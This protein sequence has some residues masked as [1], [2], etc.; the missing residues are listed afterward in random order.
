MSAYLITGPNGS[1]KSTVGRELAHSGFRVFETDI[2]SGISGWFD[3]AT[4]KRVTKL[5]PHPFSQEWLKNHAWL[6]D[7]QRLQEII[8]ENSDKVIFFCGGAY[9]QKDLYNLFKKHFTLFV[10]D[11]VATKRLQSR[12]EGH[13]WK[14]GSAELKKMLDWNKKSKQHAEN[15]GSVLID[16]SRSV[17]TIV[18]EILSHVETDPR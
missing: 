12:G 13:R 6:W 2:E 3:T 11:E 5:P 8:D 10:N 7:Q 9:N 14:D 16:S 15:H 4:Q 1:G 18:D 17:E